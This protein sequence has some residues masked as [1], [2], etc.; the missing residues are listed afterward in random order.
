M[1]DIDEF[2]N[3]AKK[4][5]SDSSPPIG[6]ESPTE[7]AHD[8]VVDDVKELEKHESVILWF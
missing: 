7:V 3:E 1:S 2:V 5:G 8:V 4:K 6:R